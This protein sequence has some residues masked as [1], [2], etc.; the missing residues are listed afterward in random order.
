MTS[1]NATAALTGYIKTKVAVRPPVSASPCFRLAISFAG[2]CSR[3]RPSK[4]RTQAQRR[5][6]NR[7]GKLPAMDTG[8]LE[9]TNSDH[10]ISDGAVFQPGTVADLMHDS[11]S[12]QQSQ[13]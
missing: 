3:K 4:S 8:P 12:Q 9:P 13:G 10:S 6:V 1:V 7:S 11:G 5:A 2:V